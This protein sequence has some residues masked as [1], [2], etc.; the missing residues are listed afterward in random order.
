MIPVSADNAA[1]FPPMT[2]SM[3][4]RAYAKYLTGKLISPQSEVWVPGGESW[5]ET[6]VIA[7]MSALV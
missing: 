4:T 7:T 2:K 6:Y 5:P 1:C 3:A